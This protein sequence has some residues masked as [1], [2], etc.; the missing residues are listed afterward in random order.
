MKKKQVTNLKMFGIVLLVMVGL[1]IIK[2]GSRPFLADIYFK[3]GLKAGEKG[4]FLTAIEEIKRAAYLHPKEPIY[5]QS[6]G[7]YYLQAAIAESDK[8]RRERLFNQAVAAYQ[9]Y[10]NMVSQDAR[11]HYGLGSVYVQMGRYLNKKEYFRTAT[12]YF[13]KAL[14]LDPHLIE[15]VNSLGAMYALLGLQEEAVAIYQKAIE[16]NPENADL[17]FNLGFVYFQSD[18]IEKSRVYWQKTLEINPEHV[19]AKR[20]LALLKKGG[21]K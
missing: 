8:D 4:D 16:E 3:K 10:I 12:D 21:K 20:G 5:H 18:E 19:E 11:G 9:V 13:R 2:Y 14:Q 6:L 17:Y 15:A 7:A 1:W